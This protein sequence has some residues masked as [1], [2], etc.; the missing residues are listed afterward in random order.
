[1]RLKMQAMSEQAKIKL[2]LGGGA[3]C[4]ER[5]WRKDTQGQLF[6]VL[7]LMS[8]ISGCVIC[9]NTVDPSKTHMKVNSHWE[10]LS[11]WKFTVIMGLQ[12][13]VFRKENDVRSLEWSCQDRKPGLYKKTCTWTQSLALCLVMLCTALGLCSKQPSLQEAP[14]Q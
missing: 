4:Q 5:G 12:D 14:P 9:L 8:V 3:K 10:A 11:E 2:G 1:M 7:T 13:T 6:C